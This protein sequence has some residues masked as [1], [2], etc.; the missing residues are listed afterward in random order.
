MSALVATPISRN[1]TAFWT[2][3][4][5]TAIEGPIPRPMIASQIHMVVIEVSAR[6]WVSSRSPMAAI[7]MPPTI[8][9]L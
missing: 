6:I 9:H 7:D 1:G 5:K 3:M 2:T 4:V 8:S